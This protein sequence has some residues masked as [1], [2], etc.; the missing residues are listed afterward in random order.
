MQALG[1]PT[2]PCIHTHPIK[3]SKATPATRVW[4]VMEGKVLQGHLPLC[5]VCHGG[6]GDHACKYSGI[7]MYL[8][9]ELGI[10]LYMYRYTDKKYTQIYI[11]I[12][13]CV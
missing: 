12:Y 2:L 11:Y 8:F 4:S 1:P 6:E 3:M 7:S 9:V 5:M 10:H 13:T